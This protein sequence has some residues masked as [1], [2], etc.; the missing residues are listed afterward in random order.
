MYNSI[1]T[2]SIDSIFMRFKNIIIDN[3]M[4]IL[5]SDTVLDSCLYHAYNIIGILE[6]LNYYIEKVFMCRE[7][8]L[9][10]SELDF[11][12]SYDIS[13]LKYNNLKWLIFKCALKEA[14][15]NKNDGLLELDKIIDVTQI[16]P[17]N[18]SK[19]SI[20]MSW[21]LLQKLNNKSVPIINIPNENLNLNINKVYKYFINLDTQTIKKIIKWVIEFDFGSSSDS[22]LDLLNRY[23]IDTIFNST[24]YIY[25]TNY[26]YIDNQNYKIKIE[27]NEYRLIL[28]P[29]LIS[30]DNYF[31]NINFNDYE[32]ESDEE[33][34]SNKTKNNKSSKTAHIG[35]F[36]K[37]DGFYKFKLK[38]NEIINII[39]PLPFCKM[40]YFIRYF[41]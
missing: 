25:K 2:L 10:S 14:I 35:G 24:G 30:S 18:S 37:V 22:K 20:Y 26:D 38:N 40:F 9:L 15:S 8:K 5:K 21:Y 17:I 28:K 27:D 34:E 36:N 23:S 12:D 1:E 6:Q 11:L 19:F 31:D 16:P 39:S 13:D 33:T 7:Y 41:E 3:K 4:K 29:Q 32:T